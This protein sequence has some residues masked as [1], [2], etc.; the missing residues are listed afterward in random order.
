[1]LYSIV[2]ASAK[3]QHESATGIHMP[4]PLEPH[5]H[6]PPSGYLEEQE[7]GLSSAFVSLSI[8]AGKPRPASAYLYHPILLP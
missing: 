4:L 3:R 2:L 7:K 5:P 6:L 8:R 1:M